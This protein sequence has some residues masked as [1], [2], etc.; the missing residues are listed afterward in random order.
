MVTKPDNYEEIA[1][2]ISDAFH[3]HRDKANV[4]DGLYAIARALRDLGNADASTPMGG[5]EALGKAI[6]D[7]ASEVALSMGEIAA[8]IREH[9]E[10]SE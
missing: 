8:A 4:A 2:A 6:S 9:S 7:S 5:L 3:A 10:R 1:E